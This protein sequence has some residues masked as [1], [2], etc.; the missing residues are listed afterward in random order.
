MTE[1]RSTL[2]RALA[3]AAGLLPLAGAAGAAVFTVT[4]TADT[5]D[6]ACDNDCS[7]REAVAAANARGGRDAVVLP[8][9]VY[10]LTRAGAGEDFGSTGDLD[11]RGALTVI[12][13]GADKTVVDGGGLDRVFDAHAAA[14]LEILGLEVTGGRVASWG[15]GVRAAANLGVYRALVRGNAA[16]GAQGDGGGIFVSGNLV[17]HESTVAGNRAEGFAG[18]GLFTLASALI[19]NSTLS[20]NAAPDGFGGGAFNDSIVVN[21]NLVVSNS[22]ITANTAKFGGGLSNFANEDFPSGG[23]FP[24]LPPGIGLRNSL[25]AGNAATEKEGGNDCLGSYVSDGYNLIGDGT[26]CEFLAVA[27][28]NLVG[29]GKARIDPRLLPLAYHGGPTPTHAL[30]PDSPALDAGSPRPFAIGT[31]YCQAHDQ[32][33]QKRSLDGNADGEAR[34]D[35]GAVEQGGTCLSGGGFLCLQGGRFQVTTAWATPAG[36]AGPG[37][38]HALSTDS[39]NFWFFNPGN[40]ELTVKLLN[41]CGLNG[42]SWVFASG[43]TNLDVELEVLDTE[44]GAVKAYTNPPDTVFSPILDTSAFPCS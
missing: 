34:C 29:T 13:A 20:G 2:L 19:N 10:R 12:G 28:G 23:G 37:R 4:K 36:L 15:G 22:T 39:G 11:V 26:G 41:G 6:G 27:T 42:H 3:L 24:T 21:P 38:S 9:G 18:G 30:L 25:V 32:R 16:L 31:A 5:F 17:M 8:P 40:V 7:L 1:P 33:G 14:D 43:L 35:I 44:T